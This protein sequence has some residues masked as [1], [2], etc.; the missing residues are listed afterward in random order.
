MLRAVRTMGLLALVAAGPAVDL[1]PKPPPMY[2]P[3]APSP[4]DLCD[5]G[6]AA[7]QS[8]AVPPALLPAIARV[9]SGRPDPVKKKTRPWPWTINVEGAG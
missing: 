1:V 9:E 5:Y 4:F 3:P 6:I 7:A 2:G 8:R